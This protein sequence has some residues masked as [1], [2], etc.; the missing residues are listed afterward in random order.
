[1]EYTSYD[2][3]LADP[4]VNRTR[5]DPVEVTVALSGTTRT[6][7]LGWMELACAQVNHGC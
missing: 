6:Y 7:Q 5:L 1:M 2:G 3:M 4:D